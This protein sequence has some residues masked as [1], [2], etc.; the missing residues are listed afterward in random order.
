MDSSE[1]LLNLLRIDLRLK[2]FQRDHH[3]VDH[4][5]DQRPIVALSHHP[6]EGLGPREPDQKPPSA[7]QTPLTALDRH[8]NAGIPD[9]KDGQIVSAAPAPGTPPAD[10]TFRTVELSPGDLLC[11]P[12]GAWHSAR[13]VGVS[14]ALNL[15]FAPRNLFDQ[16][17]PLLLEFASASDQWRGGAP[18]TVGAI[19]GQLPPAVA[20]YMRDRLDEFHAQARAIIDN[21]QGMARPWLDALT[22]GPYTGWTPDP[23]QP[24]P[25]A[26]AEDRF[27][28]ARA[29][30]LRFI[31]TGDTLALPCDDGL[32]TFPA[33]LAPVLRRMTTET[34]GFTLPDVIAWPES[35]TAPPPKDII[36]HLQT[37]YRN[38]LL[39]MV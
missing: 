25:R 8:S 36:L 7:R 11:L 30:P 28:V 14:L 13:G 5:I 22:E 2:A 27:R 32:L 4:L 6:N 1:N 31:G 33:T 16:L 9:I 29:A 38:G 12:A 24:L 37:L 10:M 34:D 3:V 18:A 39:E 20:A 17:A 26:T 21:P 35:A 23:V 19:D 15:Y